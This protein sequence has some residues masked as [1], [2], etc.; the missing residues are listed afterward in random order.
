MDSC[1]GFKKFNSLAFKNEK[2]QDRWPMHILYVPYFNLWKISDFSFSSRLSCVF[3]R[4]RRGGGFI[5]K[6]KN[7]CFHRMSW[8]NTHR[9]SFFILTIQAIHGCDQWSQTY[10]HTYILKTNNQIKLLH[11]IAKRSWVPSQLGFALISLYPTT[12]PT[13]HADIHPRSHQSIFQM[14]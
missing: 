5:W 14:T 9:C 13:I 1:Q 4:R 11:N 10:I 3:F 7:F 8:L 12:N 6:L 2:P